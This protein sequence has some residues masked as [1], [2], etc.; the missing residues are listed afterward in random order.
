MF[1]R[2]HSCLRTKI[3][4]T[5]FKAF[6]K[7]CHVAI[8]TNRYWVGDNRF[9]TVQCDRCIMYRNRHA[10]F[11][12]AKCWSLWRSQKFF[13]MNCIFT[14]KFTDLTGTVDIVSFV[15]VQRVLPILELSLTATSLAT[16]LTM[17]HNT[18]TLLCKKPM[19]WNV[20]FPL[21]VCIRSNYSLQWGQCKK[22]YSLNFLINDTY[23]TCSLPKVWPLC[24]IP[25]D[26]QKS[27]KSR[28]VTHAAK[29]MSHPAGMI[30]TCIMRN[31]KD[32]YSLFLDCAVFLYSWSR[33]T[34]VAMIFPLGL[35]KKRYINKVKKQNDFL[36]DY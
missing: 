5:S 12:N 6:K 1:S 15:C 3:F 25:L 20:E 10:N 13:L 26:A 17:F 16:T 30:G 35:E 23:R 7:T 29:H 27:S 4:K 31:Q 28:N 34:H 33:I 32:F 22:K 21:D 24:R 19:L 11:K 18:Q 8:E 2:G 36:N 9:G 14:F